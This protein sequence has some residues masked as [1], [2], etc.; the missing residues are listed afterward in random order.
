MVKFVS[1]ISY[2]Q[3]SLSSQPVIRRQKMNNLSNPERFFVNGQPLP[4]PNRNPGVGGLLAERR[5]VDD[6]IVW[7]NESHVF[8]SPPG[9]GT[10]ARMSDTWVMS[11]DSTCAAAV[12]LE[13]ASSPAAVSS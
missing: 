4:A 11:A 8:S 12:D 3:A 1:G 7:L 10:E 5:S 2:P 9:A 13:P 6:Q